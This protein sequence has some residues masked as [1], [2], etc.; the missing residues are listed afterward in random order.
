MRLQVGGVVPFST[1]DFPGKL[2]AVVFCQGCPWRCDYCHNPHLLPFS[3]SNADG[4]GPVKDFLERRRSL[5]D[6]VVFSGG[7]PTAQRDLLPCLFEAGAMG[8]KIGL[9]TGGANPE[10]LEAALPLIDWIGLDIK[11][12]FSDYHCI[13]G[14]VG[15]GNRARASLDLI[16]ESQVAF[17]CRTTMHPHLLSFEDVF[18]LGASLADLGVRHYAVQEF[19][20]SGCEKSSLTGLTRKGPPDGWME[21][22]N[23]L[24]EDFTYRPA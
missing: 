5:L 21:E 16:L 14:V 10:R 7:E 22:M 12:P 24:F 9:H 15:S 23:T 4:W 18:Q 1:V 2:S 19:R 8:F 17:E 13:T 11:A 6:A 20:A 3:E